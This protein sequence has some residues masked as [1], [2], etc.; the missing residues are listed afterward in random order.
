MIDYSTHLYGEFDGVGS[1]EWYAAQE[2]DKLQIENNLVKPKK[3]KRKRKK[4]GKLW[5]KIHYI[6]A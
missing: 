3:K 1:G 5:S 6:K 4:S 2:N